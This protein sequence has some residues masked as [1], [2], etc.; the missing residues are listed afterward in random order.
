MY[1]EDYVSLKLPDERIELR[2][3]LDW[4]HHGDEYSSG[5]DWHRERQN[6]N[7][8]LRHALV[9]GVIDGWCI[10]EDGKEFKISRHQWAGQYLWLEAY[11][12][13]LQTV[14]CGDE[15]QSGYLL[16]DRLAFVSKFFPKTP[17]APASSDAQPDFLSF[18]YISFMNEIV[19]RFDLSPKYRFKKEILQEWIVENFPS[20]LERSKSKAGYI[21]TFLRDTHF[22]KGGAFG[23]PETVGER[24]ANPLAPYNGVTYPKPARK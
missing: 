12:T 22:D 23:K 8:P 16:I 1:T 11:S 7:H 24:S 6:P 13:C 19:Y 4:L 18:P 14:E 17:T 20:G 3:A 10:R 21:A 15:F 2:R 5:F 9:N